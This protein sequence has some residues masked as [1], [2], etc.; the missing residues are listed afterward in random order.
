[1]C[2]MYENVPLVWMCQ[3]KLIYKKKKIKQL[4]DANLKLLILSL[5]CWKKKH[6]M[7]TRPLL[8]VFHLQK[9]C[10]FFSSSSVVEMAT[11]LFHWQLY[12]MHFSGRNI[13]TSNQISVQ[14]VNPLS[15]GWYGNDFKNAIAEYI[16]RIKCMGMSD[17]IALKNAAD[18]N[19]TSIFFY[20]LERHV[21]L[22]HIKKV[23][24]FC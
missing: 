24:S 1:M 17:E 8:T 5:C 19:S 20:Q 21:S 11:E 14:L 4:F 12:E 15:P 9:S 2:W 3:I 22:C 16:L 23:S 6:L 7:H 18:H 10:F 13:C